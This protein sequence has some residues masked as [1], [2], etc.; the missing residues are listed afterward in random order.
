M[1]NRGP[2]GVVGRKAMQIRSG[3]STNAAA[4]SEDTGS[5]EELGEALN[6]H[7]GAGTTHMMMQ[8]LVVTPLRSRNQEGVEFI[9]ID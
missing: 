8:P 9:Y 3:S 1:A 2:Y 5:A 4:A 7:A 6:P